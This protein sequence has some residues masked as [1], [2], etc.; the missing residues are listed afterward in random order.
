MKTTLILYKLGEKPKNLY[1]VNFSLILTSFYVYKI[2]MNFKWYSV[3]LIRMH[4]VLVVFSATSTLAKFPQLTNNIMIA[5]AE[6]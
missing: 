2:K 1:F 6:C 4:R 3:N 5:S